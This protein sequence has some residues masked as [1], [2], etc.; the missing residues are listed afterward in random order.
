MA[1]ICTNVKGKGNVV[2]VNGKTIMA[3]D[4]ASIR[5]EGDNIIV[6]DQSVTVTEKVV[7]VTIEGSV[8]DVNTSSGDFKVTGD[9]GSISTASGDVEVTGNSGKIK[10][11]SGDVTV[12][13]SVSGG[14][15]TMSGDI[16]H[17]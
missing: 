13:G 11:M 1:I 10:T 4:G 5:V 7:N 17:H 6:G 12:G 8:G 9:V 2:R 14:V 16:E 15:S 3:P